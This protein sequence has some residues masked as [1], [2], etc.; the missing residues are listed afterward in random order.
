MYNSLMMFDYQKYK[1]EVGQKYVPADGSKNTLT[2]VDVEK[3]ADCG[4]VVV[5]DS[6]QNAERRIDCFKLS[7]VRYSLVE[8]IA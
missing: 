6:V 2:V 7:V 8:E 5:H 1:I 3:Y 4:D